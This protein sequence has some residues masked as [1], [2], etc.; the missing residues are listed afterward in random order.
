MTYTVTQLITEAYFESS[1]RSRQFED[2]DGYQLSNGLLYLNQLLGDRAM[3]TGDIAYITQQYP[4][5]G[6]VGQET[7]FIPNCI[8]IDTLVFYIG[9]G[10]GA[11]GQTTVR[12]QMNYIDRNRYFGLP[13]A[14]NI[15]ALPVSYTYERVVGGIN[16]W[17]YFPPAVPYLFN[18]TGNFF[19]QNVALNQDLQSQITT[20]NLG[21]C[22]VTGTGTLVTGQLVINGVDQ[23]GSYANAQALATN[24]LS[25]VP[26]V[27]ATL[28]NFQFIISST[29]GV[30]VTIVT[31]GKT[32]DVTNTITFQFFSLI[33][34]YFSANY[35]AQYFDIFYLNYLE[36]QLAERICQ[37]FN[38]DTPP[39]VME[40]LNRYKLSISKM[41][42]PLDLTQQKVNVLGDVRGINYAQAAIG[43]GYSTGSI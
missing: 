20:A 13:R 8:S 7:Y 27:S 26:N 36:Y 29:T 43:Q 16:I 24:I 9:A 32:T 34:G 11:T 2:I 18:I 33:N 22:T 38:V 39:G 17:V 41:A 25:T 28:T 12:Y 23:A 42:E 4:F 19:L 3:D 10:T 37:K 21:L 5:Y 31:Q 30:P 15:N 40:Q 14:N 6:V 1:I 35:Y